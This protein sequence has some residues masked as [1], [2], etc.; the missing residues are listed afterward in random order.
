MEERRRIMRKVFGL[1]LGLSLIPGLTIS[2]MA[3]DGYDGDHAGQIPICRNNK[4][5]AV[6][7]APMK[8]ID[9]TVAGKNF[10]PDC[11]ATFIYGTTIPMEERIWIDIQALQGPQGPN[12]LKVALLRWYET[13][14][15]GNSLAMGVTRQ[16]YLSLSGTEGVGPNA[17]NLVISF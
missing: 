2:A 5:G 6:R 7:F 11:N 10:E 15:S 1:L 14:Q 16:S 17:V 4:T 8:D 9:P 13:N 3:F 12:P